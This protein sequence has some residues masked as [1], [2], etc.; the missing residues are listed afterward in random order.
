MPRSPIAYRRVATCL[1]VATLA[2]ATL[3]LT[4]CA[5][6]SQG[7]KFDDSYVAQIQKGKT[8][9]AQIRQNLGEPV[10]TSL[11]ADTETWTYS[12]SDAYG[13]GYVQAATFGLVRQKSDDQM[14]IVVFK[15]DVVVEFTYTK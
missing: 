11:S 5:S 4:G 12:Y 13:R 6:T 14:L 1:A 3:A 15:G 10:S 8:T 7:R 9:K 2:A